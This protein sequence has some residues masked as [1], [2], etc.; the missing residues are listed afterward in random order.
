MKSFRFYLPPNSRS[1]SSK[2]F[3]TSKF[4]SFLSFNSTIAS[5]CSLFVFAPCRF[6][7]IFISIALLVSR[8]CFLRSNFSTI[9]CF[10]LS[11]HFLTAFDFWLE[12]NC[13]FNKRFFSDKI[14]KKYN[15]SKSFSHLIVH[16]SFMFV[17]GVVGFAWTLFLIRHLF[18]N[19][20]IFI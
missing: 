9:S 7:C 13:Y 19:Y 18:F 10:C 14:E 8:I 1:S 17:V 3:F 6:C 15:N 2:N 11:L 5:K 12:N 4:G 16:F 20:S